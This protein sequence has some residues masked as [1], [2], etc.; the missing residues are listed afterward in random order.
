MKAFL[1]ILLFINISNVFTQVGIGTIT[2]QGKLDIVSDN[3][4]IVVPRVANIENVTSGNGNLAING[5]IVYDLSREAMCYRVS[6]TWMCFGVDESGNADMSIVDLIYDGFSNYIKAS[7]TD[8]QDYFGSSISISED[9]MYLAIGAYKESSNS[10]VINGD[11]SNNSANQSGAVYIFNKSGGVWTQEAYIKASNSGSGD[12]FGISVAL[13]SDGS[14][15]VVGASGEDSDATGIEGDQTNDNSSNSGA[16]Y[17]FVRNMSTWTQ[18]N[19]IKASNTDIDDHFGYSVAIT[20]GGGKIVVGAYLE[21]SNTSGIGGDDSDNSSSASGAVYVFKRLGTT[22]IQE[23]YIKASNQGAGDNF[24]ENVTFAG[25]GSRIAVGA[26]NEEGVTHTNIGAVYIYSFNVTV[27]SEEAIIKGYTLDNEYKFGN[28]VSLSYDGSYLAVGAENDDSDAVGVGGYKA[29]NGANDS[30]AAYVFSRSGTVWSEQ[31]YIKASNT[32]NSDV[33]GHSIS[34]SPDGTRLAVGAWKESSNAVGIGGD[35]SDNSYSVAGAVYVFDRNG[36]DWTQKSYIK[37]SNNDTDDL[38]GQDVSLSLD[39]SILVI[40]SR[41][42]N[43]N[44][45]GVNGDQSNNSKNNSGA[46]YIV[47]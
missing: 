11:Q 4:G 42:E 38:F 33:F 20:S 25:N 29:N 17:V 7:N 26:R 43:S 39:G 6:G 14:R 12:N 3:Q 1:F 21:D 18:E 10:N 37:S 27:W 45:T 15:L 41:N 46:V 16:V 31:V 2:P 36:T 22:W 40:G 32:D 44:A 47:E 9:G 34:I 8:P 19:Y 30:G 24:G 35:Q 28:C 5:T 23:E 13:S